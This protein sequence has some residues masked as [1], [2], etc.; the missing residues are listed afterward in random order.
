MNKE[1][2][3]KMAQKAKALAQKKQSEGDEPKKGVVKTELDS[4][5]RQGKK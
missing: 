5:K 4:E 2:M 1:Q 3:A